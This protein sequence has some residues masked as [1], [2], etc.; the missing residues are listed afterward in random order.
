MSDPVQN[1][2]IE[3][4]LSSIRRLVSEDERPTSVGD[5]ENSNS[6]DAPLERLVLTPALRVDD[7]QKASEASPEY[8][9]RSEDV[10]QKQTV[11]EKETT[12]E[13]TL[14]DRIAGLETAVAEQATEFEPDGSEAEESFYD[15]K[16]TSADDDDAWNSRSQD[17]GG[18]E[19]RSEADQSADENGD[20]TSGPTVHHL[21]SASSVETAVDAEEVE[22]LELD[23]SRSTSARAEVFS[24]RRSNDQ[25]PEVFAVDEAILDE[26]TLREMVAEIVRE[27]LQGALGER[28]TR[29][30][31]KLVRREI[32]RVLASQELD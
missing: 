28:I 1:V 11:P 17:E 20:T 13:A 18:S 5:M 15:E 22:A 32:H 27:E 29:N 14:S 16:T 21:G 12:S 30:V 2:E 8:S 4:V 24:T 25:E 31:R 26:G 9:A 7:P 10:V 19:T 3:D 6:N 23:D